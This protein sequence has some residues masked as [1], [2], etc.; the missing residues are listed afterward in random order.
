MV[1]DIRSPDAGRILNFNRTTVNGQDMEMIDGDDF[2]R[3]M[4]TDKT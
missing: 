1:S 3:L 2:K 4:A